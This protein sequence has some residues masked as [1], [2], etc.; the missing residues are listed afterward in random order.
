MNVKITWRFLLLLL[1][2]IL[3][4]GT[5]TGCSNDDEIND[6]YMLK[7]EDITVAVPGDGFKAKVNQL[8]KIEVNSV[9]DDALTYRWFIDDKPIA[10]TKNLEHMFEKG[11]M[12]GLKLQV[13]QDNITF[14]YYFTVLVEYG[15]I[16]PP[17]EGSN[18]FITKVFDYMPAVGQFTNKLPLYEDGDTQEIMN[19]KVLDDIGNNN[20]GMITLGGFGG[21]V[22]VGFDHTIQNIEGKRD[23]RVLGN[24]FYANSNPNPN[25]PEGGCCE[26]GVIMVA[27]DVN[28]NGKPDNDE[29]FEIAGSAHVNSTG[30]LWYEMAR[31]R[32]NDVNTY[33]NYKITYHKPAIE[34]TS[35]DE[36]CTYI[37]WEDN[38]GNSGY[39][40]KNQFHRQPYYPLWA[41]DT[42][43]F[44][45]TC[46]PQNGIDESGIGN[47]FVLYKFRYGYADNEVNTYDDASID[48][49]WAIDKNGKRVNLPGVDFIKIYCGVN[50]E[51]GWLGECSTEIL[52]V[53]DLHLL[54]VDIDTR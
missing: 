50:Q 32:G 20:R 41:G 15:P 35:S 11:G 26:P 42:L 52:G 25:A 28:A 40:V 45:G 13:S 43:S 44:T 47:Y 51:N 5:F 53:E 7:K 4:A 34:P 8:F 17:A 1:T 21:Y 38:Q 2:S 30:E 29:W 12:F 36:W 48:I 6:R 10:Q 33:F 49:S 22:V 14:D 18:P 37:R 9:S 31:A 27:Y 24:A 16:D 23:F 3:F 19:Q 54:G 46:L 39:K